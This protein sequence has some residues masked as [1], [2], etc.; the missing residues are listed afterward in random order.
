M[1]FDWPAVL[2]PLTAGEDLEEAAARGAMAE[3]MAGRAEPSQIAA[4]IVALRAK[5]ETVDEMVGLVRAM[6]EVAV[7]VEPGCR[8]R[9][10]S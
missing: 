7:T 5:G 1:A 4:F 3:I 6:Y 8:G 10:R 2:G 9:G